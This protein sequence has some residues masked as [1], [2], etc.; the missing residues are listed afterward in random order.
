MQKAALYTSGVLFAAGAFF[1]GVRLT[2]DIE[3]VI[4]GA[5][6]PQWGSIPAALISAGLALWMLLA[7]R[8]A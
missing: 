7:A 5:V 4:G 8:R 6:V 1:H 2:T 3:I